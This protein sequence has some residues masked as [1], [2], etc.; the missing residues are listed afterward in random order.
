MLT[1]RVP[2][3]PPCQHICA[4]G[5][6]TGVSDSRSDVCFTVL[7]WFI[8]AGWSGHLIWFAVENSDNIVTCK[9]IPGKSYERLVVEKMEA[10]L[11]FFNIETQIIDTDHM[12]LRRRRWWMRG[13]RESA[14]LKIATRGKYTCY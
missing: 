6:R 5:A 12:G 11:P 9:G 3:H 4:G 14:M 7:G 8:E 10:G 1:S 2:L 13:L